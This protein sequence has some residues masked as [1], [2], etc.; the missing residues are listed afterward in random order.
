MGLS[1]GVTSFSNPKF[2]ETESLP[3]PFTETSVTNVNAA[4]IAP[5]LKDGTVGLRLRTSGFF[6]AYFKAGQDA[7]L[8]RETCLTNIKDAELRYAYRGN[9]RSPSYR[10]PRDASA[11]FT[12][13]S[14]Q[15]C[16][17]KLG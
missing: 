2:I 10:E 12:A 1:S 6:I 13:L 7:D 11:G 15:P 9:F 16:T 8:H 5:V 3:T 14:T 17:A 4:I